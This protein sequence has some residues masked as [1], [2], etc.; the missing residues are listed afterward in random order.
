MCTA[1]FTAARQVADGD[2]LC[3]MLSGCDFVSGSNGHWFLYINRM[4]VIV[5]VTGKVRFF[6]VEQKKLV[7]D[8]TGYYMYVGS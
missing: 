1:V 3:N 8:H 7:S 6:S 4:L 5:L 2:K